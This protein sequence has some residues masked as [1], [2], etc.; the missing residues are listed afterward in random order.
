MQKTGERGRETGPRAGFPEGAGG[1]PPGAGFLSGRFYA[2][3][4]GFGVGFGVTVTVTVTIR[5]GWHP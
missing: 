2:F 4:F 1:C 5:I 3:G